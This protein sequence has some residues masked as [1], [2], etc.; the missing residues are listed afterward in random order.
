M[1]TATILAVSVQNVDALPSPLLNSLQCLLIFQSRASQICDNKV[2][3]DQK[4]CFKASDIPTLI[5]ISHLS[6]VGICKLGVP[7]SLLLVHL[8]WYS[9][10]SVPTDGKQMEGKPPCTQGSLV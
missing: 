7:H 4:V 1:D 5:E 2:S 10:R 6:P 9:T 3:K 8:V